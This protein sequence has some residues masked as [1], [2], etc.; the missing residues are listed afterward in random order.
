MVTQSSSQ[1]CPM[2]NSEPVVMSLKTLEECALEESFFES[3]KVTLKASL[4]IFPLAT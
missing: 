4:M 1:I 2:D 3:C